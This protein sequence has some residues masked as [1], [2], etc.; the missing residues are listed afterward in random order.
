MMPVRIDIF[1]NK[2]SL[3]ELQIWKA[4]VAQEN[5]AESQTGYPLNQSYCFWAHCIYPVLLLS[6]RSQK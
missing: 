1:Q 4:P 5:E 2:G 6:K 3:S